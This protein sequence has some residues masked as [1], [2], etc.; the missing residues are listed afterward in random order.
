MLA[1]S[2][3]KCY[4]VN[5][6]YE[7]GV[8]YFMSR[9]YS[10]STWTEICA[11][12]AMVISGFAYLFGGAIRF[13]MSFVD[14][15]APRT[16]ALLNNIINIITFVG[17]IALIVAIAIP[18]WQ[19]VKYKGTGWKVVYWIALVGFALGAVLGL[20]GGLGIF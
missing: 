13:I 12:W 10:T 9:R 5:T 20:L 19:F 14:D 8:K 16:M 2:I 3:L 11:F 18:A 7:K 6:D 1:K 4:N 15:V 17:N